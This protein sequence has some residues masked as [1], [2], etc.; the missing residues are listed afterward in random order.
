MMADPGAAEW[1]HDLAQSVERMRGMLGDLV[2]VAKSQ[3]E[4][5]TMDPKHL[6]TAQMTDALGRRLRALVYGRDVADGG[7]RHARDAG[8]A[9]ASTRS[10][11]T[12]SST[13]C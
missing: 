6:R 12:G 1:L 4:F 11:S 13:T 7:L 9:S 3:R 5:V 8:R 10:R 2:Q